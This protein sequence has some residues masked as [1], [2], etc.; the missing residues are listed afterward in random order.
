MFNIKTC[1]IDGVDCVSIMQFA[2]ITKR[3]DN[4]IRHLITYGNKIRKMKT[5]RA[6]GKPFVPLS[7]LFDFPF[8]QCGRHDELGYMVKKFKEENGEL[9]TVDLFAYNEGLA[10]EGDNE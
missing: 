9:V 7:E 10:E 2:K 3:S 5:I 1:K 4:S 6:G 8:V